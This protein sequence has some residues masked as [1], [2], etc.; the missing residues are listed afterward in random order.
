MD[1]V[2]ESG[3]HRKGCTPR[4]H[5]FGGKVQKAPFE[6]EPKDSDTGSDTAR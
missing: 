6:R 5:F 2:S 3:A 1:S 4:V